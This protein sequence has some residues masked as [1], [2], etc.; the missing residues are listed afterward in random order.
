[1]SDYLIVVTDSAR[2]RYFTLEPVEFP[3]MESG[4]QL[5]EL[6]D[7]INP[8]G[9]LAEGELFTNLKSGRGRAPQ[10]GPAHGYDDHR[11][12]HTDELDKRFC[13]TVTRE[14]ARLVQEQRARCVV[15]AAQPRILG[16]L[17]P[18]MDVVHRQGVEI[19]EVP[20]DFTKLPPRKIH[21]HL[22]REDLLPPCKPPGS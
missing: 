7:L 21:E 16:V 22:S 4:P 9:Q 11:D 13:Q 14:I 5:V 10:G 8:E 19:F 20:R 1:M 15:L 2:A 12:R 17:R 6:Q 3:E 18:E